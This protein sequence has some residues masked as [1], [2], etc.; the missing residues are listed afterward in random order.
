MKKHTPRPR[1]VADQIQRELAELLRL[2]VKDPRIGMV[3]IT[4]VDVSPD[5]QN[6]KVFFTHLPG[7][8]RA[9]EAVE[10]LQHSAGYLRRELAHRLKLY[11][12]PQLY[13]AYDDS[14]ESGLR[15]SKLIDEAVSD[16]HKH[17]S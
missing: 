7:A 14:I 3:T 9:A 5:L 12:V 11:T 13:F 1:R 8:A 2:H 16:D 15:I 6:A 4:A 10:A 17:S